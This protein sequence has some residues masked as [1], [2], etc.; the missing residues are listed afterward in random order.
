MSII[1][2]LP[3]FLVHSPLRPVAAVELAIA[4]GFGDM[5]ALNVGGMV[6]V[7]DGARHFENAVVGSGRE[8]VAAHGF[9]GRAAEFGQFNREKRL[10]P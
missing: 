8:I 6:K 5:G 9:E 10:V 4:D 3:Y 1:K 7:G 2:R